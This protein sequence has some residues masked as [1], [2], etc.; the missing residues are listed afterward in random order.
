MTNDITVKWD[1]PTRTWSLYVGGKLEEG[2]FFE[3]DAALEAGYRLT[4][5]AVA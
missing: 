4:R 1:K 3:R 2:G 5:G